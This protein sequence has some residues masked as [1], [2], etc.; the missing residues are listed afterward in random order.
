MNAYRFVCI[1]MTFKDRNHA[2]IKSKCRIISVVSRQ[3]FCALSNRA[4]GFPVSSALHIFNVCSLNESTA[5]VNSFVYFP[6][7][8]LDLQPKQYSN[9]GKNVRVLSRKNMDMLHLLYNCMRFQ[10]LTHMRILA[11][12]YAYMHAAHKSKP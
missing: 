7:H 5:S 6:V 10:C 11:N 3:K 1:L 12:R 4:L 2:Q 9:I 8:N